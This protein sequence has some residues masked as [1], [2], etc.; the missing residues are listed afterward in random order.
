MFHSQGSIIK[1][2]LQVSDPVSRA[3]REKVFIHLDRKLYLTGELVRFSVWCVDGSTN[4]LVDVSK[5]IYIEL[6]NNQNNS[7]IR[8]KVKLEGGR[9]QGYIDVPRH[10]RTGAYYLRAFTRW[11]TNSDPSCFFIARLYIVNPFLPVEISKTDT[12]VY[13]A[14][15]E[16]TGNIAMHN[17]TDK[18]ANS[19][20]E[21]LVIS[22]SKEKDIYG[23]RESVTLKITVTDRQGS[24]SPG[25]FAISVF[26]DNRHPY[27]EPENIC[28]YLYNDLSTG[29]TE[30][31]KTPFDVL[32]ENRG[33]TLTGSIYDNIQQEPGSNVRLYVAI[34]G[35]IAKLYSCESGSDGLFYLQLFDHYGNQ[36]IIIMP[37]ENPERYSITLDDPFPDRYIELKNEVFLPGED[38]II[39][40][41]QL[42]IN[43]QIEDAYGKLDHGQELYRPDSRWGFYGRPDEYVI[44]DDYIKLPALEEVFFEI[45]K[46]VRITRRKDQY[47]LTIIDPRTLLP[48]LGKPLFLLDGVPVHDLNPV[49][50]LLDPEEV[51]RI[52]IVSSRYMMGDVSFSGIINVVTHDAEYDHFELPGYASRQSYQFL[53]VP[54]P[55]HAPDYSL[56]ADSLRYIPDYRNTLYWDPDVITGASGEAEIKFYTADEV[57]RYRIVIQGISDRGIPGY[58]ESFLVTGQE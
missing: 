24:P 36:D 16:K 35:Q 37:A 55:F 9:G 33:I 44:I 39:F 54:I 45:V 48:I 50:L 23:T 1:A 17:L 27:L 30:N 19:L 8:E 3:Y 4:L 25:R 11:M 49:M 20:G 21:E 22:I 15:P 2:Q 6:L 46:S 14:E 51:E 31:N 40:I 10:V 26:K 18:P 42:M 29:E 52:D 58:A 12:S 13:R 43:L 38:M 57:T 28:R 53:Q 34:P 32:P 56:S 5:I 47:E 41:R 7:I